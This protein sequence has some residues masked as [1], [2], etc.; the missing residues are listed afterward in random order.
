MGREIDV[1]V[2]AG[3]PEC[4]PALALALVARVPMTRTQLRRQI[5]G[6]PVAALAEQFGALGA[7]L[8]LELA[9]C[10]PERAF[11]RIDAALR[12][13]PGIEQRPAPLA[14]EQAAARVDQHQPDAGPVALVRAGAASLECRG[15]LGH[16]LQS[17]PPTRRSRSRAR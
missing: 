1:G 4:E 15:R 7:D 16:R 8:L 13:L 5:V 9:P 2:A 10:G 14:D 6:V 17:P 12:H 3:E 11:P